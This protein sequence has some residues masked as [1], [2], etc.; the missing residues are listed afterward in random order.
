M[1]SNKEDFIMRRRCTIGFAVIGCLLFIA[2]C[3]Y[4]TT[5]PFNEPGTPTIYEEPGTVGLVQGT[6]IE[7]QD[8]ISMT[9]KMV[10]DMLT[11]PVLASRVS[12]G[13]PAPQV[14]IDAEYFSNESD[15]AFNKN[16]LTDRLRVELNRAAN[17][18]M[19]FIGRHYV[20]MV[21]KERELKREGVVG[22]GTTAPAA[23]TLGADYRLG[24]RITNLVA[25]SVVTGIESRYFLITFEMVD[26][27]TAAIVWSNAYEFRKAAG[28]DVIY[29]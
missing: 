8:I 18:R 14:I 5:R 6:G 16:M 21:E 11:N 17:G 22:P 13:I 10:G 9:Q 29:R 27:E 19:V 4:Y 1:Q 28:D 12:P 24:G 20:E 15:F 26:Q 25:G 23:A 3:T 7:S 2:G